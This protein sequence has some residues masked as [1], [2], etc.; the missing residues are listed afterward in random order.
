MKRLLGSLFAILL[1]GF[2]Q[3]VFAQ[4]QVTV[5][6]AD[7]T[8]APPPPPSVIDPDHEVGAPDDTGNSHLNSWL[9]QQ[10]EEL[11]TLLGCYLSEKSLKDEVALETKDNSDPRHLIEVRI[12][13]L[14]DFAK[15]NAPSHC[16]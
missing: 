2:T 3:Q 8:A 5:P 15:H 4:A 14:K 9:K 10:A 1:F 6:R 12:A 16:K 11:R 13:L 7:S